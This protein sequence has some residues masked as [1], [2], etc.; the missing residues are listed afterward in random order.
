MGSFSVL[1]VTA[2]F[3]HSFFMAE[4]STPIRKTPVEILADLVDGHTEALYGGAK[5]T[6]YGFRRN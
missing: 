4:R 2:L 5:R 3:W 6:T 1:A